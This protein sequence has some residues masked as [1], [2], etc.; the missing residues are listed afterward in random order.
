[1]NKKQRN[2][3][4]IAQNQRNKLINRRYSSTIKTLFKFFLNQIMILKLNKNKEETLLKIKKTINLLFSLIDK[5]SKKH[6]I[7]KNTAAR[8]K[9]RISKTFSLLKI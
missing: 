8:K 6:V 5:A 2:R 4:S 9:S 3:K 7:H 1:M